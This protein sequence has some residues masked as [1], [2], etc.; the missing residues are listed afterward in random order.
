MG[1]AGKHQARSLDEMKGE[2][3]GTYIHLTGD[4]HEFVVLV[5]M[6][7]DRAVTAWGDLA[8]PGG[9]RRGGEQAA[10]TAPRLGEPVNQRR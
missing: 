6:V 8:K 4:W 3:G 2:R 1:L 7:V 10:S 5:S 9:I